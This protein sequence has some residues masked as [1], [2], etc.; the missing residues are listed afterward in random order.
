MRARNVLVFAA[1]FVLAAAVLAQGS[2]EAKAK[3]APKASASQ[4]VFMPAND[5]KWTDLDPKG[6]PGVKI[7]DVWGNH[8]KGAY[9]AFIK[10]PAGFA[11]P[12]HTHTNA[13]KLVIVSGMFIQGPE[14]KPEVRLGPGSY[15]AQPG[16]NYRH[17]TSCDSAS[18]CVFFA[19]SNGKFDLK[20]AAAGKAGAKK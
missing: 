12:L 6:A 2:G 1:S 18:E 4:P 3:T 11:A 7:A 15:L 16:G 20:P 19:Q 10:F 8:T 14:G 13:M 5:L 17:T 9:G